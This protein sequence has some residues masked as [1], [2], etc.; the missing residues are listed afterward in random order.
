LFEN[1][2]PRRGEFD[3]DGNEDEQRR[4]QKYNNT[5]KK[6]SSNRLSQP[7]IPKKGFSEMEMRGIA[8]SNHKVKQALRF[9]FGVYKIVFSKQ[10]DHYLRVQT[11]IRTNKKGFPWL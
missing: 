5:G 9:S 3:T 11:K 10:T 7:L 2:R 8:W 1:Y 4:N 6:M